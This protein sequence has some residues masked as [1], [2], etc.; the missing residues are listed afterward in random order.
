MKKVYLFIFS[1][2]FQHLAFG[3]TTLY[4]NNFTGASGTTGAASQTVATPYGTGT[5][6]SLTV[7]GTNGTA[8]GSYTANPNANWSISSLATTVGSQSV[9]APTISSYTGASGGNYAVF[10]GSNYTAS[11]YGGIIIG[12]LNTTGYQN[13][14]LTFGFS[15]SLQAANVRA[16]ATGFSY[17]SIAAWVNSVAPA[18]SSLT[19][20]RLI[21]TT[22]AQT[23]YT[24]TTYSF[25]PTS[26]TVA[27]NLV[28]ITLPAS[29]NN[30]SSV[31][32]TIGM[33]T[34]TVA[35]NIVMGFD[36]L[37]VKGTLIPTRTWTGLLFKSVANGTWDDAATWNTA[38]NST[39]PW[40]A[41][42]RAPNYQDSTISISSGT[43][44]QDTSVTNIIQANQIIVNGTLQLGNGTKDG[45]MTLIDEPGDEITVPSGGILQLT[46][47]TQTTPF[48]LNSNTTIHI[49]SGGEMEIGDGSSTLYQIYSVLAQTDVDNGFTIFDNN[50]LFVHNTPNKPASDGSYFGVSSSTTPI[51]RIAQTPNAIVGNVNAQLING[52]LDVP[53]GV[54]ITYTGT[55]SKTFAAG[56]TGSGTILSSSSSPSGLFKTGSFY[57]SVDPGITINMNNTT[58]YL[59]VLAQDFYNNGNIIGGHT[60]FDAGTQNIHGTGTYDSVTI[61]N[62]SGLTIDPTA[63]NNVNINKNL[64]LKTGSL[65]TNGNLTL[66]S[67]VLNSAALS[68]IDGTI[69][70]GT[71]SGNVA[72]Q[73]YIGSNS[74]WRMIGFPFIA[75][76]TISASSLSSMY[77]SGYNAY[78][79]NESGD[80]GHYG[81]N[82][83]VNAGWAQFTSGTV[84]SNKGILLIGGTPSSTISFS[85]PVNTGTQSIALSYSSGNTNK[86]WNLIANPFPSNI[87]WTT[88]AS[89]NTSNL[90]NAIYRYDP[91][92]TAYA[93]YVNGQN[94]GNQSNVIENGAGFFVHST[95]AT[96]LSIQESDKTSSAPLLSLMGSG[97]K[98]GSVTADGNSNTVINA[99]GKSIIKMALIK[100][101]EVNGDEVI[102][103]WGVDPA[104]DNFDGK[105]DAYDMG[106]TVGADLSVIGNDGTAYSIFHGSA[107][108]TKEQEQRVIALGTKNMTEGNYSINASLMS[109]MYDDNEVY[110]IDHYTHQATLISTASANYPFI[111]T[112][113]NNSS[114]ISRFSISLNYKEVVN[115]AN[116]DLPVMLLNNPSTGNLFTLYSKNNYTQLQWNIID[117]S[118]R[119]MQTGQ[120]SNVTNGSTYQINTGNVT[121]G[122]YYIKLTGD[123]I[124]LPVLK[125]IKN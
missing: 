47:L 106:R 22:N 71:I 58:T 65:V 64:T 114:S 87:N 77:G 102:V 124:N 15:Y 31:Y 94:T 89:N 4:S 104:T 95:G 28:S 69:N 19:A 40:I 82:G 93:S 63:G 91:V 80:N 81:N 100:E 78:T 70:T 92:T 73:R 105:Y 26:G 118:G 116:N 2:V 21:P 7:I 45:A 50:A 57:A 13:I 5:N 121:A 115:S 11:Q 99:D 123:G 103:R 52:I 96:T 3:Q 32:I 49:N 25:T 83:T 39:G 109:A 8:T 48:V 24:Y 14:T 74:V 51:L 79:Y 33:S 97:I 84:T 111:V 67:T 76:T 86:G 12:P 98:N 119:L 18:S 85:A 20:P 34:S 120:L 56:V 55:G 61:N 6:A 113:D 62:A 117:N 44:V 66:L 53:A 29:A 36:D 122:N 43:V 60:S 68:T 90:D 107:L 88:I 27:W 46:N 112:S 30:A 125:A 16:A 9:S 17:G 72:V 10:S 38:T 101:G 42:T 1:V 35:G 110:L 54:I 59:S 23:G 108:Q 41:A 37:A 75:T